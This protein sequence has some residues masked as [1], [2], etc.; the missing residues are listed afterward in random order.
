MCGVVKLACKAQN[1]ML[2]AVIS[3]ESENNKF[4]FLKGRK[5]AIKPIALR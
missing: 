2:K 4:G 5:K 1:K 3:L